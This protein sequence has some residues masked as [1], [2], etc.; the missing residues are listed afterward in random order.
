MNNRLFVVLNI[1]WVCTTVYRGDSL[2]L[3]P[4]CETEDSHVISPTL[5]KR[6]CLVTA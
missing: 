2:P 5:Q 3:E 4:E 6:W 1:F